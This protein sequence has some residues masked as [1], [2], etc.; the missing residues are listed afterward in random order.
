MKVT[1]LDTA[2]KDLASGY[3]FYEKH[4]QGLGTYFFDSLSSDIDSLIFF[5]GTYRKVFG[6]HRLLSKRFP[7]AV[8]Y[9]LEEDEILVTAVLDYRRS[10]NWTREKPTGS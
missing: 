5:G 6:C 4:A 3:H 9:R 10:P 2:E 8:Y 7:F 1:I